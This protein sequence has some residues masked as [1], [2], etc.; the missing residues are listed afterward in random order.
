MVTAGMWS[1]VR[2]TKGCSQTG[3]G[4]CVTATDESQV[5]TEPKHPSYKRT[6]GFP[7][8]IVTGIGT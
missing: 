3:T 8:Q 5:K 2:K 1:G 4:C 7:E 6:A